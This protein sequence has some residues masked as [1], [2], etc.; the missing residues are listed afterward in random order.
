VREQ[1]AASELADLPV[2][3]LHRALVHGLLDEEG[4]GAPGVDDE[5]T[6]QG[7]VHLEDLGADLLAGAAVDAVSPDDL[8]D[9]M[10]HGDQFSVFSF[11]FTVN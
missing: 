1:A 6:A 9:G 4:R 8:G 2:E 11:Q 5:G 7:F 10:G 3:A